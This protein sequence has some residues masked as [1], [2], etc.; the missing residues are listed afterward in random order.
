[1]IV[2]IYT[3]R[4]LI[5]KLLYTSTFPLCDIENGIWGGGGGGGGGGA[6]AGWHNMAMHV[7]SA[8]TH[9]TSNI[10]FYCV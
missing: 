2:S 9:T 5:P 6:G 3:T 7:Q 8:H 4:T 10:K 1:M